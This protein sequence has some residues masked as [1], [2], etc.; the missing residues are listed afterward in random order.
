M[1]PSPKYRLFGDL[2][3]V[4]PGDG[5]LAGEAPGHEVGHGDV[6]QGF[7]PGGKGFV[8]AGQV[9]SPPAYV[10]QAVEYQAPG[11]LSQ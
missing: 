5:V 7:G 1:P 11:P 2:L 8:V 4:A 9:A 10:V 6:N 3:R